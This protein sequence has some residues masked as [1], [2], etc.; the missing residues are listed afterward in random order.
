[1]YLLY[2]IYYIYTL[3]WKLSKKSNIKSRRHLI[4]AFYNRFTQDSARDS[5]NNALK[6]IIS[7]EKVNYIRH[8]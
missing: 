7:L 5:V 4:I 1:M 2:Y 8:E 6:V 3:K